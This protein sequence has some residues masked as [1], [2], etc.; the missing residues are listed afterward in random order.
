MNQKKGM[1]VDFYLRAYGPTLIII[2]NELD[3]L[4]FIKA[5]V[6]KLYKGECK[7]ISLSDY[8]IFKITGINNVILKTVNHN[9]ERTRCGKGVILLEYTKETWETCD[10]LIDGLLDGSN[11]GHHLRLLLPSRSS[12]KKDPLK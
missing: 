1:P 6:N 7:E 4:L 12:I 11:G 3:E 5:L 2:T 9:L 8:D 10:C